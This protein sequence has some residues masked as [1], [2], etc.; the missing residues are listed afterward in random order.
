MEYAGLQ[1]LGLADRKLYQTS[2]SVWASRAYAVSNR[3]KQNYIES[4]SKWFL[5]Q[6][7]NSSII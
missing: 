7:Q 2:K 3:L 1:A 5:T 4:K 6:N